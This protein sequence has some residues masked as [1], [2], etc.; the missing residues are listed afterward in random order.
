MHYIF[1]PQCGNTLTER[2]SGDDGATPYC[3]KCDKFWLF[4]NCVLVMITNERKEVAMLLQPRLSLTQ[5]TFVSGIMVPG[6]TSE[7]CALRETQEE[8]GIKIKRMESLGPHNPKN[9]LSQTIKTYLKN[10][11]E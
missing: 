3:N 10:I 9:L 6:E 11:K 1:C 8:L 4:H 7:E 5:K 2:V